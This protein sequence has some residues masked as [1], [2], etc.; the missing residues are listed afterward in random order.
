ML[1]KSE[2]TG[3]T[4]DSV[5]RRSLSRDKLEKLAN[6]PDLADFIAG[7]LDKDGSIAE[8]KLSPSVNYAGSLKSTTGER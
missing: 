6:G 8:G 4:I 7:S 2:R 3:G 1:N 5:T